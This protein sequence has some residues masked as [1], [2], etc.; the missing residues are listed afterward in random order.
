RRARLSLE[1]PRRAA[2]AQSAAPISTQSQESTC[3]DKIDG[4]TRHSSTKFTLSRSFFNSYI[5]DQD[6]AAQQGRAS[7]RQNKNQDNTGIRISGL[8][9]APRTAGLRNS[10]V[11]K[12]I[13]GRSLT[14]SV[15]AYAAYKDM[16][17]GDRF[18]VKLKRDGQLMT[19]QYTVQ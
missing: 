4:V 17:N 19:I 11:I 10:D 8:R 3:A 15:N 7:W 12:S 9:C 16:K 1:R 6:K 2:S 5:R 13:N 14:S 18:S